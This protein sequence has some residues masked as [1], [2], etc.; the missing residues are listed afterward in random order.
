[1]V[2]WPHNHGGAENGGTQMFLEAVES[3]TLHWPWAPE[4]EWRCRV[5]REHL[6]G[7]ASTQITTVSIPADS[8]SPG[9]LR[10][11]FSGAVLED[12]VVATSYADLGDDETDLAD[13]TETAI[14][15]LMGTT[16]EGVVAA[17]TVD[18]GD[19]EIR[20]VQGLGQV[21]I[22]ADY[23]PHQVTNVTFLGTLRDGDYVLTFENEEEH[24]EV[25]VTQTRL[26]GNPADPDAL[27]A[28]FAP[29]IEAEGDLADIVAQAVDTDNVVAVTFEP[30][31]LSDGQGP[32]FTITGTVPAVA[33][34]WTTQYGGTETNGTYRTR[35]AHTAL[36]GGQVDVDV[37]R[38]GGNP[39]TNDDLAAAAETAIENHPALFSL[40]ASATATDDTNLITTHVGV[41]G[42]VI[43]TFPPAPATLEAEQT[44]DPPIITTS[45]ETPPGPGILV[46]HRIEV[47]LSAIAER[48]RF[49][50]H[51]S[52][53]E[54]ALQVVEAFGAGRTLTLGDEDELAGLLGTTPIDVNTLG[55]TLGSSSDPEYRTRHEA[56]FE[57]IATIN[58]GTS[59]AI[60]AG[61]AVIM[62]VW[63]GSPSRE[64]VT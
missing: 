30:E 35:F 13:A 63:S 11:T 34:T 14:T 55:R 32:G 16:L 20:L 6:R 5:K 62:I 18:D 1:M 59:L 29:A 48:G 17:V 43:T 60:S 38:I 41:V 27:A 31:V 56:A 44:T 42:L 57:P 40:I 8:F 12:E 49:P 3:G 25:P 7:D 19:V 39:A 36:P 53:H 10:L 51:V 15:A 2:D 58:L 33:Q 46:T 22:T 47:A 23:Y 24:I 54:V 37:P 28:A 64:T 21:L 61:E 26:G 50:R 52:R 45:D 4:V 9:R